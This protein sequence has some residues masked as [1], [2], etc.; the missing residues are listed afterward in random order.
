[1][2]RRLKWLI[3][4]HHQKTNKPN[5]PDAKLLPLATEQKSVANLYSRIKR[6]KLMLEGVHEVAIYIHRFH[7]LDLFQQGWYQVKITMRWEDS[8]YAS[9]VGTP[10]RVVQYDGKFFLVNCLRDYIYIVRS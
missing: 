4:G 1:M 3:T 10:S 9:A 2:F 5:K 8:E 6:K 7:N